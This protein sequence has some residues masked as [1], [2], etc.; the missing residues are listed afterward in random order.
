MTSPES[1]P[2]PPIRTNKIAVDAPRAPLPNRHPLVSS[3]SVKGS[4]V[5]YTDGSCKKLP[6]GTQT[7]GAAIFF[8]DT[9]G[10]TDEGHPVTITIDPCGHGPTLTIN[11]AELSGIHQALLSEHSSTAQT[12]HVYTDS[13]C[14]LYLIQRILNSPW[15]VRD[16]KHFLL[17]NDI[18]DAL[19]ARAERGQRTCFHKVRS[20]IG[21]GGNEMAD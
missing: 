16:S 8:P 1:P 18:L 15:T 11:R 17:L 7:I 6:D 21:I 10:S 4:V 2:L 14:S 5:V 13:S 12:L 9:G 3:M 19:R 20:H